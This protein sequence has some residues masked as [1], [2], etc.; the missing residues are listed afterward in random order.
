MATT[1]KLKGA[2]EVYMV[3]NYYFGLPLVVSGTGFAV[4]FPP[5][6]MFP[7]KYINDKISS[8][9]CYLMLCIKFK[10]NHSS[11]IKE[12]C[13]GYQVRIDPKAFTS[14]KIKII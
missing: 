13:I 12:Y 14:L 10:Y 6:E 11:K 2:E 5:V 4:V 9:F 7:K 1:Q 3:Y 8:S